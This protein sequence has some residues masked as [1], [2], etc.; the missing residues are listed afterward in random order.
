[1]KNETFYKLRNRVLNVYSYITN[2]FYYRK[3][4]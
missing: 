3:W 2:W 1:M 4:F